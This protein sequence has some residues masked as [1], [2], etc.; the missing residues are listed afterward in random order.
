MCPGPALQRAAPAFPCPPVRAL[1]LAADRLPS[2]A[3]QPGCV[4][5]LVR[6][7]SAPG[8][9]MCLPSRAATAFTRE[10]EGKMPPSP[11]CALLSAAWLC[12]FRPHKPP[13]LG[14]F[15]QCI[16]RTTV[17]GGPVD[18][19]LF[20]SGTEKPSGRDFVRREESDRQEWVQ[21]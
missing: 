2:K 20:A 6:Q 13:Q 12:K 8:I 1:S 15:V 17:H 21:E 14:A 7:R 5:N 10:N 4:M 3:L 19:S 9:C 11:R 16:N 18:G